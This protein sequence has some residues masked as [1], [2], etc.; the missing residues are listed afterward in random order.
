MNDF[1]EYPPNDYRNYLM[2]WGKGEQAKDHK[3]ISRSIGKAGK[4]IYT[5]AKNSISNAR[6]KLSNAWDR[7]SLSSTGKKRRENANKVWQNMRIEDDRR[8]QKAIDD[9]S[10]NFRRDNQNGV[11]NAITKRNTAWKSQDATNKKHNKKSKKYLDWYSDKYYEGVEAN[12][13][14]R[15]SEDKKTASDQRK[16]KNKKKKVQDSWNRVMRSAN[17]F[18]KKKASKEYITESLYNSMKNRYP[19]K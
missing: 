9:I 8:V 18:K 10:E 16:K 5:Y 1:Y 2:H 13:R 12:K 6:N 17:K 15:Y 19:N 14:N 11:D 3:Y 7:S 4:W